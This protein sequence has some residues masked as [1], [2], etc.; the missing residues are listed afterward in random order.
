MLHTHHHAACA[1]SLYL[2]LGSRLPTRVQEAG[3]SQGDLHSHLDCY[4]PGILSHSWH[5]YRQTLQTQACFRSAACHAE[6]VVFLLTCC[7]AVDVSN[8][9]QMRT[10]CSAFV[11]CILA[12]LTLT[13]I[14]TFLEIQAYP[15]LLTY[16]RFAVCLQ[17]E[18]CSG[19]P[20]MALTAT[21]TSKV[22]ED[23][24]KSLKIPRCQH[25]QVL[26]PMHRDL[27]HLH[28]HASVD[29]LRSLTD[30]LAVCVFVLFIR[31]FA[32]LWHVTIHAAIML[33]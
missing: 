20:V 30:K 17:A 21:A 3:P 19:L 11:A 27:A 28:I 6:S 16:I 12:L 24:I 7:E 29:C 18:I 9:I 13:N 31:I 33:H 23:I 25:F 4:T 14:A 32:S 26:T 2:C 10:P 8:A 1:G 22:I 5:T 15:A